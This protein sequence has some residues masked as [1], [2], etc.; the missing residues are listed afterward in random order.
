[1]TLL[2]LLIS[3]NEKITIF[4]NTT[5]STRKIIKGIKSTRKVKKNNFL[6]CMCPFKILHLH[7]TKIHKNIT[8]KDMVLAL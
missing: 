7:L 6:R 4:M 2:L 8:S 5:K 3:L 1:M